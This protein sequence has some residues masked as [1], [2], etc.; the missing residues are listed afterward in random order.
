M[1]FQRKWSRAITNLIEDCVITSYANKKSGEGLVKTTLRGQ[2][3]VELCRN[4]HNHVKEQEEV[5]QR[6]VE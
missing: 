2:Y 5:H 3:Q 4:K 1:K 6:Q